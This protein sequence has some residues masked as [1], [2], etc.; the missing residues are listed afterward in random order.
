MPQHP[1]L[2]G[3]VLCGEKHLPSQLW[4]KKQTKGFTKLRRRNLVLILGCI[5]M[6]AAGQRYTSS[7]GNEE[8]PKE[9]TLMTWGGDFVPREVD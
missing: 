2:G 3:N 7:A 8:A 5:R 9:I 1:D 4:A 6:V